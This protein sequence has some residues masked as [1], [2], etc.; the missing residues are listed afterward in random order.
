[1]RYAKLPHSLHPVGPQQQQTSICRD[2]RQSYYWYNSKSPIFSAGATGTHTPISAI[3]LH[4]DRLQWGNILVTAAQ[5]AGKYTTHTQSHY[6]MGAGSHWP[7]TAAICR[8][9]Y[10]DVKL[11]RSS[12]VTAI[13]EVR[14]ASDRL[15]AG[16]WRPLVK[17]ITTLYYVVIIFRRW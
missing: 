17:V 15:F 4:R 3:Y 12:N 9:L 16:M 11:L 7:V 13:T 8:Y 1:M 5:W 14:S 10:V 2:I 6:V